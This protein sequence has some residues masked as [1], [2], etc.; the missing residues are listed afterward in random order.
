MTELK[1]PVCNT[2][3]SV[4]AK[5]QPAP[6]PFKPAA[7]AVTVE[8]VK[9]AF[10]E[11]LAAQLSFEDKADSIVLKPK[12]FLGSEAFAKVASVV[13]GIGGSYVSAGRNSHFEINK[14]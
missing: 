8:T 11:D 13:R 3:L 5:D 6:S 14:Q 1:C 2:I 4:T 10:P 9:A 12:H 7:K